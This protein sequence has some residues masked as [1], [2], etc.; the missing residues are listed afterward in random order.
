MSTVSTPATSITSQTAD[1]QTK[2]GHLE[3]YI[4]LGCLH[5]DQQLRTEQELAT[6]A[7][8]VELLQA[9]LPDEVKLV[10]GDE[11]LKLLDAR[12]IRLFFN[13]AGASKPRSLVRVY[14]LPE[15]WGRRFI[16]RNSRILK[17]AVRHLL[18]KIDTSPDAWAGNLREA[19]TCRFDP[20]ATAE[21]VSLYYLFNKLPSPAP[22]PEKIKSRYT[23]VAVRELLQSAGHSEWE[24]HGEQPL[25]GLKT[26]LYAYQARS[27]SLMIQ[28]EA[29]PALQLDPRLEVRTSPNGEKF[30]FSARDGSFLQ[31]PRYYEAN[32]GGI[33]AET[34][35][36]GKTLICLAI[37]LATRGHY[38]QIPAAYLPP[39]R[40]RSHVGSLSDMAASIIGR[41]SIP[42]KALI[43]QAELNDDTNYYHLKEAL[44]R[45][46]PFYEIPYELPRMN[47]KT[48]V[49]P[50][51]QLVLCSGSIIVVPRNLLH[52]W[53]SEI[54]KHVI[55]GALK[56]LVVDSVKRGGKMK[57]R[58]GDNAME[59][60]SDLPAP[61]ELM[62]F[63]VILFTRNRFEQEIQD[64]A[65]ES[66]RRA[67]TGVARVCDCT[68]IGATRIPDC[69]CVG[70]GTV[71]ES[72]LKKL[73]WLR[74]I[75]DEGHSFS[76][77]ASNAVL[78]AKQIQA[79]RRWVISGS[80][81]C[82]T[83]QC[84]HSRF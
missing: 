67:A 75:I 76:S 59:F 27:A 55:P 17:A 51:R 14:L 71:Y 45:N 29:A 79:E 1:A 26:R 37:I 73:H 36:L 13:S 64:G 66:G 4:A 42:A 74:V 8:W 18:Q 80:K 53:Q 28:R 52:Q 61:T 72:P 68:Y 34:M 20:W 82:V 54:Q 5:L 58:S 33:L 2:F 60:A 7:D 43:E 9:D 46:I 35:G 83:T 62:K 70:S 84:S 49:P 23:R 40:A 31:E 63:D 56:V 78:V 32:R 11:A 77:S 22:N 57:Q 19:K 3:H 48:E 15:D 21:N 6:Q 25:P 47:R 41:H 10:I 38:P 24:E 81:S 12:W 16:D 69:N 44:Q 65:D 50:P 30:F 39:P